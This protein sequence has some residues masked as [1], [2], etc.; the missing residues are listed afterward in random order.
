MQKQVVT[1]PAA[2]IPAPVISLGGS[3]MD[4]AFAI[5]DVPLSSAYSGKLGMTFSSGSQSGASLRRDK[6]YKDANSMIIQTF[7]IIL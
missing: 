6:Y 4:G 2:I 7:M 1:G 5:P 3:D